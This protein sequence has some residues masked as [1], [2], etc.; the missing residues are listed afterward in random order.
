MIIVVIL[1]IVCLIFVSSERYVKDKAYF[2]PNMIVVTFLLFMMV[3]L[4]YS[5]GYNNGQKDAS[6]GIHKTSPAKMYWMDKEVIQENEIH[7]RWI[8]ISSIK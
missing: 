1:A 5:I 2:P 8:T 3:W 7:A 6:E 4:S